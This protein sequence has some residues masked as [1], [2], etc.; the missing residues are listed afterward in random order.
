MSQIVSC[1]VEP[2][3]SALVVLLGRNAHFV[4]VPVLL[5]L[6]THRHLIACA[7]L[8]PE[9]GITLGLR[10]AQAVAVS[11][12]LW[13]TMH[14]LERGIEAHLLISPIGFREAQKMVIR[15]IFRSL[16]KGQAR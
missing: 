9:A 11:N 7:A 14:R 4:L 8:H 5:A 13:S 1:W 6:A 12:S 2:G 15:S 16:R 3:F 10:S